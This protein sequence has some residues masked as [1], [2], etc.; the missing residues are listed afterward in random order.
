MQGAVSKLYPLRIYH[1]PIHA[2]SALHII[3]ICV[4]GSKANS[5]IYLYIHMYHDT[6]VKH[7]RYVMCAN[8]YESTYMYALPTQGMPMVLFY[9]KQLFGLF[10]AVLQEGRQSGYSHPKTDKWN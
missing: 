7:C 4:K 2:V 6:I 5:T 1:L 3:I 10:I 9:C 8:S